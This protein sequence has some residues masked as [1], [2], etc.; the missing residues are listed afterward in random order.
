MG[1]TRRST[2]ALGGDHR[3]AERYGD[4]NVRLLTQ[5]VLTVGLAGGVQSGT[6]RASQAAPGLVSE[7]TA[8][9]QRALVDRYCVTC[10]NPRNKANAG[11]LDLT[12]VDLSKPAQHADVFEKVIA[13]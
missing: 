4:M 3:A 7:T 11:Q 10:H 1:S 12:A 9:A 6:T 2:Q 8:A 13:K 5:I